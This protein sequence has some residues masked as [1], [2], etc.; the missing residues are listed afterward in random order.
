MNN[1]TLPAIINATKGQGTSS[2]Y[3]FVNTAEV[4][5]KL[6]AM[7]FEVRKAQQQG[8]GTS[9]RHVVRLVERGTESVVDGTKPEL[10]VMN[11]HDGTSSLRFLMGLYRMV[12]SNGLIVSDGVDHRVVLRHSQGLPESLDSVIEL[13]KNKASGVFEYVKGMRDVKV[14]QDAQRAYTS[15]VLESL[16]LMNSDHNIAIV[17]D[18][19]RE[20]DRQNSAWHVLN[21]VQENLIKGGLKFE[22]RK[23]ASKEVKGILNDFRVNKVV[24][25]NKSLLIG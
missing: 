1:L 15:K 12:C 10:I 22:G 24:W 20:E 19:R 14:S 8:K 11:A 6:E 4:L 13:V 25:D 16:S 17:T 18:A 21:R 2:K 5:A 3:G 7:G 23:R 9:A